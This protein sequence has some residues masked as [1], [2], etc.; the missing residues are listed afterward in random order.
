MKPNFFLATFHNICAQKKKHNTKLKKSANLKHPNIH[1][2]AFCTRQNATVKTTSR[3][4]Q[5]EDD[6]R[7]EKSAMQTSQREAEV[8]WRNT[9]Y[10]DDAGKSR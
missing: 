6:K 1:P 10:H 5:D 8:C 3:P 4:R 7:K 2:L 9:P